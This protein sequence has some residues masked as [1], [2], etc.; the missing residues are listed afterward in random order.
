MAHIRPAAPAPKM[1]T[2]KDCGDVFAMKLPETEKPKSSI[3]PVGGQR[4]QGTRLQSKGRVPSILMASLS[5]YVAAVR[6]SWSISDFTLSI[7]LAAVVQY[8]GSE[9][10]LAIGLALTRLFVNE[11]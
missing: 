2:W 3:Y 9:P 6:R 11:R 5:T 1:R 10:R 8:A 7:T 4:N